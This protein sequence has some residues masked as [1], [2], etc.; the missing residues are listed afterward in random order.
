MGPVKPERGR[1]PPRQPDPGTVSP[2]ECQ[3]APHS[4]N[5][6]FSLKDFY[7]EK[8]KHTTA[9]RIA[10]GFIAYVDA[11]HH[12]ELI[13]NLIKTPTVQL[14][15]QRSS[16]RPLWIV[17]MEGKPPEPLTLPAYEALQAEALAEKIRKANEEETAK[18]RQQNEKVERG[19]RGEDGDGEL[20][21]EAGGEE[22]TR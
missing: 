17:E 18:K 3:A 1:T 5:D 20:E 7:K 4:A 15:Y 12:G 6:A 19:E 8:Y 14:I 21:E 11:N 16:Q 13:E 10:V 22:G 9:R 2:D